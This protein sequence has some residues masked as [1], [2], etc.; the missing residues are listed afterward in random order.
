M[1]YKGKEGAGSPAAF[2]GNTL[3]NAAVF[4][5]NRIGSPPLNL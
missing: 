1:D 3:Q 4:G 5:I 2:A